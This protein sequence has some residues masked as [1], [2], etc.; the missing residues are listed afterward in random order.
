MVKEVNIEQGEFEANGKKYRVQSSLS[1][2]RYAKFEEI[3][4]EVGYGRSFAS[5]F[6]II[7][8]AM[9]DINKQKQGEAYVKLYNLIYG[10]KVKER[11]DPFIYRYCALFINAE[12]EDEAIITDD[13]I[14][15]KIDDWTK[16][17]LDYAPFFDFVISSLPG[18]KERYLKLIQTIS[19]VESTTGK[20]IP[21]PTF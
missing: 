19:E 9:D 18:F 8:A 15:Q 10:I 14:S 12:G 6:D 5:V 2:A 1:I 3:E 20:K 7:Q 11:K 4:I 16:E 17:G 21:E 13:M